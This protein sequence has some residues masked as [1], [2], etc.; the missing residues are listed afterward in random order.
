MRIGVL[1]A[2]GM[3]GRLG[4]IWSRCGHE[5][6]F[7]YARSQEKLEKLAQEAGATA[8]SGTPAQA[9]ADADVV[10][11]AVHWSRIDDVLAQAGDLSG[12]VVLTC[13]LAMS[14]DNSHLVLGHTS[15]GPEALAEKAPGAQVVGA[16]NTIP[17]EIL[18]PLFEA[19]GKDQT[20]PDLI[21]CGDN[22]A[23]KERVAVLIRDV[24][25]NPV[26]L[27][28]LRSS[29]YME[30]F[31]LVVSLLAYGGKDGPELGYRFV[32]V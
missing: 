29:R 4:T 15:S 2:G 18:F 26:D 30:P 11:I 21:Y 1:G 10:L 7:S 13:S 5:V 14:E 20:S 24:G 27:G 3:G 8:R 22:R 31:G 17:G 28:K 12:K 16:F 6:T 9:V 32:R 25:F 19:K 23:A